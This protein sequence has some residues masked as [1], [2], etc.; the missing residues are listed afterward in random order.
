MGSAGGRRGNESVAGVDGELAGRSLKL[1]AAV[2]RV[3]L[4]VPECRW[5]LDVAAAGAG[6][7]ARAG[8]DDLAVGRLGRM[9]THYFG[10]Q[11]CGDPSWTAYEQIQLYYHKAPS[12]CGP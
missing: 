12:G 7:V 2:I 10:S 6:V 8:V 9:G 3:E 11:V 1:A 5:W 4:A